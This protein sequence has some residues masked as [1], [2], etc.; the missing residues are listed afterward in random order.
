MLITT[1]FR[2][3]WIDA[4]GRRYEQRYPFLHAGLVPVVNLDEVRAWVD[5]A[6]S[7]TMRCLG[8]AGSEDDPA[9]FYLRQVLARGA[10]TDD[11]LAAET[12]RELTED[13]PRY[14]QRPGADWRTP[15]VTMRERW[16]LPEL[17]GPCE[18]RNLTP[19]AIS[20]VQ[21][22]TDGDRLHLAHLGLDPRDGDQ[23]IRSVDY[24]TERLRA[25]AGYGLLIEETD[26]PRIVRV[27]RHPIA[28][29]PSGRPARA[30]ESATPVASLLVRVPDP[31]T[32]PDPEG[33][34]GTYAAP[35]ESIVSIPTSTTRY[36]GLVDLPAP[37]PGVYLIVSMVIPPVATQFG[38]WTGD[39][40]VPGEQVRDAAG[41]IVGCRSLQRVS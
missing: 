8:F 12:A 29:P 11:H 14:A 27:T 4:A 21:P 41:R 32:S 13:V 16:P 2:T 31:G 20:I 18:V 25:D 1:E 15:F 37:E 3:H 22:L 23:W 35:N 30:D 26:N 36:T 7:A 34:R 6:T 24:T 38:R 28:I 33:R 9:V 40:L 19:H 10:A 39:L 5:L 17:G